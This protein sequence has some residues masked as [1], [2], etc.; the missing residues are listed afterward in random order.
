LIDPR[1]APFVETNTLIVVSYAEL[2]TAARADLKQS[3][4]GGRVR[5]F[6]KIIK[7]ADW[8]HVPHLIQKL[9]SGSGLR[10]C[11]SQSF[12]APVLLNDLRHQ[13]NSIYVLAQRS[14]TFQRLAPGPL[15]PAIT[16]FRA[17]GAEI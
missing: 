3:I 7:A 10:F 4:A 13:L 9:K 14:G 15:A 11:D 5:R 17:V 1:F 6:V 16:L 8:T 12:A 2:K